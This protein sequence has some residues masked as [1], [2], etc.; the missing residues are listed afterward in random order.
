MR[1]GLLAL[2]LSAPVLAS[3]GWNHTGTVN[4]RMDAREAGESALLGRAA[5]EASGELSERLSLQM[6]V[7]GNGETSVEGA[8]AELRTL[9]LDWQVHDAVHLFAGWQQQVWGRADEVNPLDFAFAEDTRWYYLEPRAQR[10]LARL[11]AGTRIEWGDSSLALFYFPESSRNHLADADSIWCEGTCDFADPDFQRDQFAALGFAVNTSKASAPR[12][13]WAG[14]YTSRLGGLD[15]GAAVYYGTDHRQRVERTFV[16]PGVVELETKEYQSLS[17]G[18]DA[19]YALGDV[20]ARAELARYQDVKLYIDSELPRYLADADGLTETDATA[21]ILSLDYTAPGDIY[22]NLQYQDVWLGEPEDEVILPRELNLATFQ[23]AK[24]FYDPDVKIEWTTLYD[25]GKEGGFSKLEARW[26]M[27]M[28][29]MLSVGCLAFDGE[30]SAEDYGAFR[31][32]NSVYLAT[33][34]QF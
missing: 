11:S 12:H 23:I 34:Y 28:Q 15:F 20:V 5:V 4:L 21:A 9:L 14:R 7:E 33:Q 6:E 26:Q 22:L 24:T 2:L 29:W 25:I 10:K 31:K 1:K 3:A 18:V 8:S 27:D 13:E 32:N 30:D 17:Y 16:A 19:A